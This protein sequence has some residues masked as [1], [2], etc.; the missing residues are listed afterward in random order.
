LKS[1]FVNLSRRNEIAANCYY[2]E[3]DGCGFLLDAGMHP[4]FDGNEATPDLT[5]LD[6]QPLRGVF[7]THA[8]HDHTGALPLVQE[9]HPDCPVFMSEP[10][11]FLADPLLH[12]SVNVMRRQRYEKGIRECPLYTHN[13]VQAQ[14]RQWH[15]C[16]YRQWWSPD[17][18][19]LTNGSR[20]PHRFR[21]HPA[22]HILGSA[23][24]EFELGKQ[25]LLYTG[26]V[27]FMDQT[28]L[29]R[30]E[31]PRND[32][33]ILV[34]ET[35]RGVQGVQGGYARESVESEL[36]RAIQTTFDRNG[37]V[38]MPI[39]AMGKTQEL[40]VLLHKAQR[41]G[42]IPDHPLFIGGLGK[43]FS[44]IYDRFAEKQ[45][46]I[47]E[48]IRPQVLDWKKLGTFKPK[49]G[50]LYLLPSGMMTE[51][52]TS[53][54][55]A[56]QFLSD[57]RHSVFFV[58]YTDP[59]SPAGHLRN[60]EAGEKVLLNREDG[61]QRIRCDVRHFDFTSHAQREDLLSY[62]LTLQPRLCFLVH[63]DPSALSWF[64][65]QINEKAP[66]IQTVIPIPGKEYPL[67][68]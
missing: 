19:S 24:F 39:F 60:T 15:A 38:L 41:R 65:T 5:W 31:L 55:L 2:L 67:E 59:N 26:D 3:Q 22:G 64:E 47:F 44:Q 4:K 18:H 30:A 14:T 34:I 40:L 50:H 46:S 9:R 33:D 6:R 20:E 56:R 51:Q 48:D 53:N 13:M 12:N 37:A 27:N 62:I 23:A 35:T 43:V 66:K 16:H 68:G 61:P 57:P 25:R 17:G 32:I 49:A 11:Y 8:H 52:T 10:T 1:R 28:I 45:V 29:R 36:I 54:R 42:E 7:L 58:G 63:G 21:L